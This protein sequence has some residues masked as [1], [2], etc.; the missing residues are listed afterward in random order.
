MFGDRLKL[1]R[2]AAGF[3]LRDLSAKMDCLISAQALGKYER[4]EMLPSSTVLIALAKALGV[5]ESYLLSTGQLELADV[6][7]RKRK[8]TSARD[9]AVLSAQVLNRVE[10]YLQIEDILAAASNEW[11][12]PTNFPHPVSSVEQAELAADRLRDA[13][14]LGQDPIPRL[15]EFLEEQGIKVLSLDGLADTISGMTARIE[16]G[17][18]RFVPMIVINKQ[19]PGERQRFT[20]AHE[21]GHLVLEPIGDLDID[22]AADRFAGAFLVPAPMLRAEVGARRH[23][24]PLGELLSLKKLFLASM[25]CVLYRLKDLEIINQSLCSAVFARMSKLGWRMK[26]PEPLP[27]EETQRFKRLVFRSMAEELISESKAAEL[28]DVTVRELSNMAERGAA[29]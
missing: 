9:E 3:S 6:A 25:Q 23:E 24:I 26:E 28:L 14:G 19:H 1:A 20:L 13:W 29:A 5:S 7:F 27:P 18:G 17:S 11:K 16:R 10:K 22:K 4:D 12:P 8:L 15:A 2:A 21:L